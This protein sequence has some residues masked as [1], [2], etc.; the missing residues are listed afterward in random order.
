MPVPG[1]F[2][3]TS[4]TPDLMMYIDTPGA[5]S[6]TI[7]SEGGNSAVFR[8]VPSLARLSGLSSVK[9]FTFFRN[10]TISPVSKARTD[11]HPTLRDARRI[12]H[13]LRPPPLSQ[14]PPVTPDREFIVHAGHK[15][16]KQKPLRFVVFPQLLLP[17]ENPCN[18]A[19]PLGILDFS[20]SQ[21]KPRKAG[22]REDIVGIDLDKPLRDRKS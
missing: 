8:H 5:P 10:W 1:S 16:W 13:C 6:R 3:R 12:R 9:S 7:T 21:I 11:I 4:T 18:I 2:L 14:R 22:M 20:L 15:R 17:A 19:F